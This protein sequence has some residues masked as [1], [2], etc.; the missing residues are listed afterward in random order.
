MIGFDLDDTLYNATLLATNARIGGLK[1]ILDCGLKYDLNKGI[2]LL[3]EIVREYGSNYSMHY[4]VFLERMKKEPDRYEL[5][6]RIFSTSKYVAAGV[7]GYHD[8]KVKALIPFSEVKTALSSLKNL[9][10]TLVLISDGLAIK[11]YEKLIRL[12]LLQYFNEVF[13]SEEIG[14]EKP[15]SDLYQK[16]LDM[17]EIIPSDAFYVGDRLDHDM[18][19]AKKIGMHTVLVHRGGKYDPFKLE[20]R[21]KEI[22]AVTDYEIATLLELIPIIQAS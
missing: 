5:S 4:N 15:N 2:G 3:F 8:V 1:K 19:P 14:L 17:M 13:I 20:I 7:M 6:P 16:C 10:F 18:Q 21:E 12:D 22:S 11:Q 9:G